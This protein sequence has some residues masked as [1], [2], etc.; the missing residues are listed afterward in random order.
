[1]RRPGFDRPIF[2]RAQDK[3]VLLEVGAK[4]PA[5]AGVPAAMERWL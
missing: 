3:R 2:G 5:K 4:L 1:M